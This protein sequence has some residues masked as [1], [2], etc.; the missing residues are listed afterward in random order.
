MKH[1]HHIIPKHMGGL[2]DP[3][4]IVVLSIE[5]HADAHRILYEQN[6]LIEDYLAWKGLLGIISKEEI[7][8]VLCSEGGKRG[9]PI[10]GSKAVE[11]HKRNK[12][13]LW[14]EDKA[15]Q[16]MGVAVGSALGGKAGAA[17]CKELKIGIFG[18]TKEEKSHISSL[19][20]KATGG[21]NSIKMK[22][23]K[24]GIFDPVGHKLASSKGGKAQKGFK[25]HRH[26]NGDFKMALP[27]S[28]KSKELILN[29]YKHD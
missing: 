5:E 15:I 22:E 24:R 27:G 8:Q 16:K 19:G 13:G 23:E 17:V 6:G 20:G 10:G 25:K 14:R 18:Y 26:V 21:K 11:T 7:V 2:D 12:T 9:G 3:S 29:G 4:N 1:K 28:D